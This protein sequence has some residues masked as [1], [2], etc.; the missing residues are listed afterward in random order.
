MKTEEEIRGMLRT[1][2]N[3]HYDMLGEDSAF[4]STKEIA[5][6]MAM[7]KLLQIILDIKHIAPYR[8]IRIYEPQIDNN[9]TPIR[10]PENI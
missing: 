10:S 4:D 8:R 9:K 5:E 7:I 1:L 3:V 2:E 6:I